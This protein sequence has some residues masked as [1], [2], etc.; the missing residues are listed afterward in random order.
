MWHIQRKIHLNLTFL[1]ARHTPSNMV[2]GNCLFGQMGESKCLEMCTCLAIFPWPDIFWRM[3]P[4][5]VGF[6]HKFFGFFFLIAWSESKFAK[7]KSQVLSRTTANLVISAMKIKPSVFKM[8]GTLGPKPHIFYPLYVVNIPH[9]LFH[10][11]H[12]RLRWFVS[13]AD[14]KW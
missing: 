9:C 3:A 4:G 11:F 10:I 5:F 14:E 2:E 7:P 8:L 1:Y 13:T 12:S 6:P